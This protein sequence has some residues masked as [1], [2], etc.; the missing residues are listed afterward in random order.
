MG[1]INVKVKKIQLKC[2]KM[3]VIFN[4]KYLFKFYIVIVK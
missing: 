3:I 4:I 1:N 2:V